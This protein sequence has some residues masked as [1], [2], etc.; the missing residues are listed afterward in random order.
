LSEYLDILFTDEIREKLGG[1]YSIYSGVSV[2]VITRGEYSI[3]VYFQCNTERTNELITA[4]R[5][6]LADVIK[7][8]VNADMF[9]KAKEALLK[10][11]E[12]SIQRNLYIAQSYANSSVLYSTPLSRLNRRPGV[13]RD[14]TPGD[15]QALC[16]EILI[17]GPVQVILYPES[18]EH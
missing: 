4:V 6:Y 13:I 18:W 11:H 17:S 14:V 10:E 1:V 15:L 7:N 16:S 8:N 9:N 5:D 12:S 3:S 2:S